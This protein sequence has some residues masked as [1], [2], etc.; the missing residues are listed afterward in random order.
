MVEGVLA[1]REVLAAVSRILQRSER[2]LDAAQLIRTYVETGALPQLQNNNNQILYGRRG[3]GKT[4]VLRVL[5]EEA[6][7]DSSTMVMYLD[8]RVLGST[9]QQQDGEGGRTVVQKCIAWC[10][11]FLG[12]LHN[13]LLDAATDPRQGSAPPPD[14]LPRLADLAEA[15]TRV[16]QVVTKR[17]VTKETASESEE[18]LKLAAVASASPSLGVDGQSGSRSSAKVSE[19]YE[20]YFHENLLF[21]EL[22][23]L[24]EAAIPAVGKRRVLVLLDEWTAIPAEVQ[25]YF[26]EFIRR[27]L[28]P[29]PAVTVK[30]ASLEYR[31]RFSIP[32]PRNN[33]LG[34][35]LGG[36]IST[37]VDLDD[38]FVYARNPG[39]VEDIFQELLFK[40]LVGAL[41]PEYLKTSSAIATALALRTALFTEQ[42]TFVE[43]VRAAE[44]VA[45]DFIQI[46][47]KTFLDAQRRGRDKIDIRAVREAARQHYEKDKAGNLSDAQHAVLER[48]IADVIGEK[49][50][51]SF[52]LA[53]E[54]A[55][56]PMIE[57]LFD[58][59]VVH[60]V[61]RGYADKENPGKRYNIYTLDYGTYV[62]LINTKKAPELGFDEVTG[63]EQDRVVPFDDKRSIR[64]I[65]LSPDI[66]NTPAPVRVGTAE[67]G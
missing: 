34:F 62:D 47:T 35:E 58:L 33:H 54:H 12:E 16:A 56:H 64:R 59:R 25:P 45:R 14:A 22:F 8:L 51:R 7:R 28:L 43:L 38:Y 63:S 52:L 1:D 60:L 6:R 29:N 17:D 13:A 21:A 9:N 41:P 48:V 26:A 55:Q 18:S 46:F 3:T 65:V 2:E 31:S 19:S 10:K 44:G 30:I 67:R 53:R 36:D 32:L 11:D 42:N 23:R 39:R 50:A 27:T 4:H 20:Q 61:E 40:H 57:S 37:G 15:I 24:V 66:L 5:G 49:H